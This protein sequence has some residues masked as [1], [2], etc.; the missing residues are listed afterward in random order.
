MKESLLATHLQAFVPLEIRELYRQGGVTDWHIEEAQQRMR[1]SG[2][3][4]MAELQFVPPNDHD[5]ILLAVCKSDDYI[6][7]PG[8]ELDVELVVIE[9]SSHPHAL[10]STS[11]RVVSIRPCLRNT[12]KI[13]EWMHH[14]WTAT[15]NIVSI[16]VEGTNEETRAYIDRRIAFCEG[17]DTNN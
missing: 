8:D 15:P 16:R 2:E 14:V 5:D 13:E 12:E 3:D 17:Y 4:I 10:R 7:R 1:T 11:F 9:H 6:P